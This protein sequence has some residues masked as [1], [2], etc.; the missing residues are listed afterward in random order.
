MFPVFKKKK[1]KMQLGRDDDDDDFT[2]ACS[3]EWAAVSRSGKI[4]A[5]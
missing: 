2:V 4:E 1:E 5:A 3:A